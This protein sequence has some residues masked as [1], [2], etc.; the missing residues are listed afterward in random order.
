MYSIYTVTK[1]STLN[2]RCISVYGW[3]YKR[4]ACYIFLFEQN[5]PKFRETSK[6]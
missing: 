1:I 4:D 5:K 6:Q 2:S 3:A